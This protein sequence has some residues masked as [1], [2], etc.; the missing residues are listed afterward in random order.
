MDART[1]LG[2]EPTDDPLRWRLPVTLGLS[3]PGNFLFGGCGLAAGIEALEAASGR[4][5]IWATAQYLSYAP[6]GSTL[7]IEVILAVTGHQMTQAR[8]VCRRDGN[9]ILTV[10]AALGSRDLDVSGEWAARPDVPPP[11][12][13][14]RRSMMPRNMPMQQKGTIMDRI[15]VRVAS[16]RQ[17]DELDGTPSDDGRS[18]MWARLPDVLEPSAAGLAVFGDFVP[19]G[20]SQALGMPAGGNSLDNTLRV[21]QLVPTDWVLIDLRIQAV[22]RGFGHGIAH[23][24]AEDGTLLATASQSAIVRFWPR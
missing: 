14:P 1:F 17:F 9:E 24:W 5:C 18:A 20:I 16:G 8:A 2:L 7:D 12:E 13:A 4:R 23:L 10:N 15:E 3:T 6:T 22:Q 11:A 19:S 21:I